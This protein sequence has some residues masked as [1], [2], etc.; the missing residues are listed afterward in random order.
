MNG[1][2]WKGLWV[3]KGL[4]EVW[5]ERLNAIRDITIEATCAGHRG[6]P[7]YVLYTGPSGDRD[8]VLA[9]AHLGNV[10]KI[11]PVGGG[12]RTSVQLLQPRAGGG[13]RSLSKTQWWLKVIRWLESWYSQNK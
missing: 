7:A 6:R 3:D 9:L 1:K 2:K 11:L 8:V 13:F 10:A 4:A 12:A 5:L